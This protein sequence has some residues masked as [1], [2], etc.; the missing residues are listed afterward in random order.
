MKTMFRKL[1]PVYK[2]MQRVAYYCAKRNVCEGCLF[3][4]KTL[5][6]CILQNRDNIP[7]DWVSP[8]KEDEA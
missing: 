1:H 7:A 6:G 8:R 4:D 2:A 5:E 3:S